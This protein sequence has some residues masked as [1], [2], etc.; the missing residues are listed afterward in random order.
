[1]DITLEQVEKV[2]GCT[3]CSYEEAKAALG[4]TGGNVLDA[5]ILLERRGAERPQGGDYSTRSLEPESGPGDPK[6]KKPTGREVRQ[7]VGSLFSNCLAITLEVWNHSR[8]TC[9]IPLIIAVALIL[10]APYV[11]LGLALVGLC[12][13]YRVHISGKGTEGWGAR[14]NQVMDQISGTVNDAFRQLRG[15]RRKNNR[16]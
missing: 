15:D 12:V 2:R 10:V 11:S 3:G 9:V 5:V 13:G 8:V 1:M 14:F 6:W 4:E 7:A 16:K